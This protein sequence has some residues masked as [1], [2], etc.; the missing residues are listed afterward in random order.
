VA[1]LC[2]SLGLLISECLAL[3]WSD[4]DWLRGALLV[5]HGIVI[6]QVDETKTEGSR[7]A[8]TL[9]SEILAVLTT[10][11]TLTQFVGADDWIFALRAQIRRLPLPYPWT[12]KMFQDAA[13]AAGL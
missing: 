4:I 3:K 11:K 7:R 5:Q 2:V 1:A 10:C 6:E 12:W 13:A 9:A 8:S